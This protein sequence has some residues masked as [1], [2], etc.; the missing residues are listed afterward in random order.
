MECFEQCD[1]AM[2]QY[3]FEKMNRI[4]RYKGKRKNEQGTN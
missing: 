2:F 3:C 1:T 4:D